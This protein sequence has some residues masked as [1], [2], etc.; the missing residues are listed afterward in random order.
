MPT[1]TTTT[2]FTSADGTH[3]FFALIVAHGENAAGE[4]ISLYGDA[5]AVALQEGVFS[6]LNFGVPA[7]AWLL[8]LASTTVPAGLAAAKS[9]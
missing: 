2:R 3:S 5:S 9:V 4:R 6:A 1:T 8:A 7:P